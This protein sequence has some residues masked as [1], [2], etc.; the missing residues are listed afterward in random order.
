MAD[1]AGGLLLEE[2]EEEDLEANPK[3]KGAIRLEDDEEG[4]ATASRS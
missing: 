3:G 2:D 1:E 4:P